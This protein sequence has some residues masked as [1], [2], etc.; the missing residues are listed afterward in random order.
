MRK[1]PRSA[2]P[3][4][5]YDRAVKHLINTLRAASAVL[6]VALAA[7]GGGTDGGGSGAARDTL[8][9]PD[10]TPP[11][12]ASVPAEP[13]P[14]AALFHP[15][16]VQPGDTVAGMV[17][18]AKDVARSF[19][20]GE[21]IGTVRFAGAVTVSG[22]T[23]LHPDGPESPAL[24]F[25]LDREST[26]RL[27]RFAGDERIGW[28]CFDDPDQAGRM[29]AKPPAKVRASIVIDRYTYTWAHSD[30]VNQARL[31]RVVVKQNVRR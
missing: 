15:D 9:A 30:V 3:F 5:T 8:L 29:L 23:R 10:A 14:T 20:D 28:F 1:A 17:V 21:W 4:I 24:C 25:E 2:E 7:C 22:I 6:L 27:P 11:D 13:S 16:S 19:P 18:E 26:V 31:A 12:T